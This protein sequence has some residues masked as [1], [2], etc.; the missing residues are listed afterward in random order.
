MA[1]TEFAFC[2]FTSLI[3]YSIGMF[4]RLDESKNEQFTILF[5][6]FSS[7]N[8]SDITECVKQIPRDSD[9]IFH[10][11]KYYFFILTS[12]NHSGAAVINEIFESFFNTEVKSSNVCFPLDGNDEEELLEEL[13]VKTKKILN[14]DLECLDR[15]ILN[16]IHD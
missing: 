1:A 15:K 9:A 11:G 2:D 3:K 8:S 4:K 14:I 10:Y 16:K 5:S 12:T 7:Y 6:D 13:R